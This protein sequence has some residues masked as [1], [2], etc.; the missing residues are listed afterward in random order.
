V[1]TDGH[2]S[3]DADR[4]DDPTKAMRIEA[5]SAGFYTLPWD[6]TRSEAKTPAAQINEALLKVVCH[7]LC[8]LIQEMHESGAV[9]AFPAF[10]TNNLTSAF[11]GKASA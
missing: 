6:L 3:H 11:E 7:N 5:A 8:C 2:L 1:W 9:A 10:C 4:L